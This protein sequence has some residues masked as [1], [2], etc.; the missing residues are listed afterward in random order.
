MK[1]ALCVVA[2]LGFVAVASADIDLFLT[3]GSDAQY[4]SAANRLSTA[5]TQFAFAS[6]VNPGTLS[7]G[8]WTDLVG[9]TYYVWT[10]FTNLPD[11]GNGALQ[12]YGFGL[13]GSYA[14]GAS[15]ANGAIYRYKRGSVQR[16]D[17]TDPMPFP[18]GAAAV[19]QF[20][21]DTSWAGTANNTDNLIKD[22]A[23]DG[24]YYALVG[25]FA[26]TPGG[27]FYLGVGNPLP[28]L[29][30]REKDGNGDL[31]TDWDTKND[32][33]FYPNFTVMG[34]ASPHNTPAV[35]AIS[36]EPTSMLL[37]GLA[38]LLIRRR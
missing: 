1:K 12:I 31:I 23:G 25:A 5:Q 26:F 18:G 33:A 22:F 13:M 11:G 19:S 16:W 27:K 7:H 28:Y 30:V 4:I 6:T 15:T 37:L 20:G 3:K 35:L 2:L 36:P 24:S 8:P 32:A 34:I 38:G 29:A 14:T 9:D 21:I 10:H 17:S